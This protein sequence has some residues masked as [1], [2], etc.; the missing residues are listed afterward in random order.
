[1]THGTDADSLLTLDSVSKAFVRVQTLR[2][3]LPL[4]CESACWLGV[5]I[6]SLGVTPQFMCD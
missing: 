4:G 1:M 5:P 6:M 3:A 2:E